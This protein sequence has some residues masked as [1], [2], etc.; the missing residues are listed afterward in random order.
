GNLKRLKAFEPAGTMMLDPATKR[1]LELTASMAEGGTDGTLISI[2]DETCTAM[3]GRLLRRRVHAPLRSVGEIRKRLDATEA[4][5]RSHAIR[6]EIRAELDHVGDLERL[7]SRIALGRCSA[8]D[9]V[10]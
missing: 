3:G 4:L 8:R 9:L 1:N 10:Q 5:F 7:I 2:L 6:N